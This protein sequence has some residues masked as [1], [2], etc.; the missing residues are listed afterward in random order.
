MTAR[1]RWDA[2]LTRLDDVERGNVLWR[3]RMRHREAFDELPPAMQERW[4]DYARK[5]RR[6]YPQRRG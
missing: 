4:V 6:T 1:E 2:A 3:Y 5:R